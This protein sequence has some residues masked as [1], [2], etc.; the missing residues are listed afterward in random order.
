MPSSIMLMP[1][2]L[3][4]VVWRRRNNTTCDIRHGCRQGED[5]RKRSAHIPRG[6][7]L[8]SRLQLLLLLLRLCTIQQI[9]KVRFGTGAHLLFTFYAFLCILVVCGSLLCRLLIL[10]PLRTSDRPNHSCSS[11]RC[12]N[13]ERPD[14]DE[15]HRR[16]FPAPHRYRRLRH[17]RRVARYL[18]L[19]LRPYLDPVCD[20]LSILRKRLVR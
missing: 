8:F 18:H 9:V 10:D 17:L 12:G 5:E 11:G 13:C 2:G 15:Y 20:H 3:S 6:R 1:D 16:V 14:G 19:R 4:Q 7:D